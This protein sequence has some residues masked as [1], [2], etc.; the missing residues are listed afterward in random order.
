MPQQYNIMTSTA[1]LLKPPNPDLSPTKILVTRNGIS[2]FFTLYPTQIPRCL[3]CFEH[4]LPPVPQHRTSEE[5]RYNHLRSSSEVGLGLRRPRRPRRCRTSSPWR[6][7][8][9]HIARN[10]PRRRRRLL[11]RRLL[12]WRQRHHVPARHPVGSS[13]C[14]AVPLV[15]VRVVRGLRRGCAHSSHS[16]SNSP[17]SVRK[18][19]AT[20]TPRSTS[21]VSLTSS[22]FIT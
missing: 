7:R 6:C 15:A 2:L 5:V 13:Q 20:T 4:P 22:V 16:N 1:A 12:R 11:R 3:R 9:V 19:T 10:A 18:T 8:W 17:S 14:D 21:D